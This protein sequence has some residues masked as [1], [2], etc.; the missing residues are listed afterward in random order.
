MLSHGCEQRLCSEYLIQKIIDFLI[1]TPIN[2]RSK[3]LSLL[4]VFCD[5]KHKIIQKVIILKI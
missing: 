2:L 3:I 4:L 5:I 1:T